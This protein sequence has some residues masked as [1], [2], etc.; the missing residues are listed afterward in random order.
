MFD[1]KSFFYFIVLNCFVVAAQ[2]QIPAVLVFS[3]VEIEKHFEIAY[4]RQLQGMPLLP[5]NQANFVK[6]RFEGRYQDQLSLLRSGDLLY[7]SDLQQLLNLELEHILQSNDLNKDIRIFLT[8]EL[9]V[10]AY[11]SGDGNIFITIG[12]MERIRHIDELRFVICHELSHQLQNHVNVS[13]YEIASWSTNERLQRDLSKS[14]RIDHEKRKQLEGFLVS[15]IADTRKHSR[16]AEYEADALG[17]DMLLKAGGNKDLAFSIL[18]RLDMSDY[19]LYSDK[20]DFQQF[21]REIGLQFE[22]HW[23]PKKTVSSLGFEVYERYILPDELKTHPDIPKRIYAL[24]GDTT[25]KVSDRYFEVADN[26]KHLRS[27]A[28][29]ESIRFWF[30]NQNTGR[31]F[32]RSMLMKQQLNNEFS[33]EMIFLSLGHL[34]YA[35][36]NKVFGNHVSMES[37]MWDENYNECLYFLH[38]LTSEEL[39]MIALRFKEVS[40]LKESEYTIV[41]DVLLSLAANQV[42]RAIEKK[43]HYNDLY[44]KGSFINYLNQLI[45]LEKK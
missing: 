24:D 17:L 4:Q 1:S 9:H 30:F 35:R 5:K 41:S 26:F 7:Y 44:P 43:Q 42:N 40:E 11:A 28:E 29:I 39:I 23:L 32:F 16:E 19:E 15:K 22:S 27:L 45:P 13:I 2:A 3:D 10:N 25:F 38:Q 6:E 21:I 37:V 14:K 12:L 33:K 36:K 8:G 18:E 20:I 31:V 34:A